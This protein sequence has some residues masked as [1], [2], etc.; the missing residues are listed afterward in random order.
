M[1]DIPLLSLVIFLP[2][3]G[4]LVIL[5]IKEDET[6]LNNIKNVALWTSVGVFLLSLLIWIQFDNSK[7]GYQF[8]EKFR[9]FND[10]NFYYHIGID[11][12]SLFMVILSTFLTPLC[13]LSSWESVKKRV[14]KEREITKITIEKKYLFISDFSVLSFTNVTLFE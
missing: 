8:E 10:F 4:G 7:S 13:I 12:I 14:S 9:W 5:L 11:G 6:S 1:T 3:L 2:L